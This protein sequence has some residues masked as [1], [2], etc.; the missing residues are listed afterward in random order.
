MLVELQLAGEAG[1]PLKLTVLV[2]CEEPKLEPEIVTR[3]PIGPETGLRPEMFGGGGVTEK[4]T[5]LLATPPTVTTTFPVVAA[6]GTGAVML[7]ALQAV[8]DASVPLKVTVLV[9]CVVP[10]FAPAM[11]T[12]VPTAP[13]EGVKLVMLG[14][15]G[16][17]VK[18]IPL[19][20]MPATVTR[21]LPVVADVGTGTTM[22]LEVQLVGDATVPLKLTVLEA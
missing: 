17:T 21:T 13:E 4:F 14:G 10:K 5:P 12:A 11:V 1:V 8:G 16:V 2:P 22:L 3:V 15:G 6:A 19:L 7:E 9:P 18:L 20:D